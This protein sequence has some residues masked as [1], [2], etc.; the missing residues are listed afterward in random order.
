MSDADFV[1]S[2]PKEDLPLDQAV[3]KR[4]NESC[5]FHVIHFGSSITTRIPH[6][7]HHFPFLLLGK[8]CIEQGHES[9]E[10]RVVHFG[11]GSIKRI[12]RSSHSIVCFLCT[13]LRTETGE[14]ILPDS[15]IRIYLKVCIA[16]TGDKVI[17]TESVSVAINRKWY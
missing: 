13:Q 2:A 9:C 5:E 16:K 10:F 17:R 3:N 15:R 14:V 6:H 1:Q 8:E 12:L 7:S 4:N 11:S